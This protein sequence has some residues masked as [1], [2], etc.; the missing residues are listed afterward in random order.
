MSG[1]ARHGAN[2]PA[3][4]AENARAAGRLRRRTRLAFAHVPHH[5]A[6]IRAPHSGPRDA[7]EDGQPG[8][9]GDGAAG[10]K[11]A[12]HHI[13]VLA[14]EPPAAYR[15]EVDVESSQR[16]EGRAS[17][18]H[19]RSPNL[20]ILPRGDG[21]HGRPVMFHDGQV[22]EQ[23]RTLEKPRWRLGLPP[24]PD[25]PPRAVNAPFVQHAGGRRD[26]VDRGRHVV[27]RQRDHRAARDGDAGIEGPALAEPRLEHVAEAAFRP[28]GHGPEDFEGV[29]GRAIV[30]DEDFPT[31][32]RRSLLR[33][34][35]LERLAESGG[36][37]VRGDEHGDREGALRSGAGV[38]GFG[39]GNFGPGAVRSYSRSSG[40]RRRSARTTRR[41]RAST[42]RFAA[43]L[44]PRQPRIFIIFSATHSVASS[45]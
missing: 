22:V 8:I 7:V 3:R 18:H 5:A 45:R 44:P 2:P 16:L 13:H 11:H 29:V 28:H 36:A 25:T 40:R 9:V 12:A 35:G 14:A 4:D 19:V 34:Q 38:H 26:P 37:V 41:W 21:H 17:V 24:G 1:H 27:V 6:E 15:P 32:T 43:R 39:V 23:S 10:L 30:R 33:E 31:Q 20:R 42:T